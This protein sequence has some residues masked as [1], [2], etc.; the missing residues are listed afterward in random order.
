[1][2]NVCGSAAAKDDAA[3][4]VAEVKA[5]HSRT[6]G[7]RSVVGAAAVAVTAHGADAAE[8]KPGLHEQ[9]SFVC[10]SVQAVNTD[11]AAISIKVAPAPPPDEFPEIRAAVLEAR[12]EVKAGAKHKF[13]NLYNLGQVIGTGHYAR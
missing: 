12:K 11:T 13:G 5:A 6:N 8:Q 1:M 3:S 4:N 10:Q 9:Q 7:K 2:G